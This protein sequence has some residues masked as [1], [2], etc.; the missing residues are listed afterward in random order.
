MP[1]GPTL[2]RLRSKPWG[3]QGVA[4]QAHLHNALIYG[5]GQFFKMHQ[6]TEKMQGMVL[7]LV[8]VWPCAHLGGI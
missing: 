3:L 5:P 2:R 7:T 1:C 8:L 6:D 4:L